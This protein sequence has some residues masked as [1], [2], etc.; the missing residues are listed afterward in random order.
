MEPTMAVIQM[1]FVSTMPV[2]IAAGA[3]QVL[4]GMD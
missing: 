4:M 3:N 2:D 1:R